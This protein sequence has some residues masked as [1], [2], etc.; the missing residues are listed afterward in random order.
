MSDERKVQVAC[1]RCTQGVM[2]ATNPHL[3]GLCQCPCHTVKDE[4]VR[5]VISGIADHF[6]ISDAEARDILVDACE[7]TPTPAAS[8]EPDSVLSDDG[9]LEWRLPLDWKEGDDL[10]SLEVRNAAYRGAA[11]GAW[12]PTFGA[13]GVAVTPDRIRAWSKLTALRSLPREGEA[14]VAWV[15]ELEGSL[16]MQYAKRDRAEVEEYVAWRRSADCDPIVRQEGMTVVPLYRA[17]PLPAPET[18]RAAEV[19]KAARLLLEV[20]S[21]ATIR[22][23]GKP[24]MFHAGSDYHL[25]LANRCLEA[26][27]ALECAALRSRVPDGRENDAVQYVECAVCGPLLHHHPVCA[28]SPRVPEGGEVARLHSLIGQ[29]SSGSHPDE[30]MPRAETWHRERANWMSEIEALRSALRLTDAMVE[31]GVT[32]LS[33]EAAWRQ[34]AEGASAED[35]YA[36]VRA[37]LT[38][39]LGSL[40]V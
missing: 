1:D 31:R 33:R 20:G 8:A 15:P 14:P 17:S 11:A 9:T 21:N 40:D 25:D 23:L 6:G 10:A 34:I 39:A 37:I 5:D 36:I 22:S 2:D 13:G 12:R 19:T 7:D 32:A 3:R 38:A 29:P 26:C 24:G 30:W 18:G 16:L 35:G 27:A 4:G 28:A